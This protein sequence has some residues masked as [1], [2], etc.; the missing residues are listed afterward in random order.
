VYRYVPLDQ[1]PVKQSESGFD[2]AGSVLLGLS[3]ATYAMAM[4]SGR[5]GFEWQSVA[6]LLIAGVGLIV[7]FHWQSRSTTPLIQVS[8]LR[9]QSLR[10]GLAM[11]ALVT[12]VVMSSLVIGPFYLSAALNLASSQIGLVMSFGPLVASLTGL[13]AG[14]LVDRFGSVNMCITGLMLMLLGCIAFVALASY[15]SVLAYLFALSLITAGYALFQAANNTAI[16]QTSGAGQRGMLNLARNL[17]LITG[18]SLMG[19]IFA[20]SSAIEVSSAAPSSVAKLT[21]GLQITFMVGMGLIV[22]ALVIA[23]LTKLAQLNR[24]ENCAH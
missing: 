2:Y 5:G 3:L 6:L 1:A 22:L 14:R 10:R 13:P 17:G 4:T 24:V 7:F 15:L 23:L 8:L 16:M 9:D 20:I 11:S 19:N 18:A 21:T 12:T